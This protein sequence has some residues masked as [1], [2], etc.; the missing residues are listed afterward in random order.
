[1]DFKAFQLTAEERTQLLPSRTHPL[2]GRAPDTA[3]AI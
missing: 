2:P 3:S 1:M